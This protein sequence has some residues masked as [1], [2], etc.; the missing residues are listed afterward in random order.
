MYF[1]LVCLLTH[2]SIYRGLGRI[3]NP[4]YPYV[5]YY[6]LMRHRL[7]HLIANLG[8][9]DISCVS[10]FLT[11]PSV[12]FVSTQSSVR[13]DVYFHGWLKYRDVLLS[14]HLNAAPM[15]NTVWGKLIPS[16][17]A[18][19]KSRRMSVSRSA[20]WRSIFYK[21]V[22]MHPVLCLLNQEWAAVLEW[23]A[24]G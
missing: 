3:P 12:L 11:C 14:S 21:I 20:Y 1:H 9:S 22:R 17:L 16:K 15:S 19:A 13:Q 2:P 4:L 10:H 23:Q 7:N 18:T 6:E 24:G 8:N 5:L